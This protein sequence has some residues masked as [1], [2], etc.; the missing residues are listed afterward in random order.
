MTEHGVAATLTNPPREV[1]RNRRRRSRG[2][3]LAGAGVLVVVVAGVAAFGPL[4][5]GS[6]PPA[7]PDA[8]SLTSVPVTHGDLVQYQVFDG[9]VGFGSA[10][11][12]HSAAA[13]T[14]TWLA[15][16]GRTLK[17]GDT[18]LRVDEHPVV[19]LYGRLPMYRPLV[20]PLTGPDVRQF[21]RNL[22]QLGYTGFI[23]DDTYST[24]TAAAVKRWQ[25]DLGLAETGG[26][27]QDQVVYAKKA[28]R[29]AAHSVRVG[30]SSPADILTWT[31][32][33][34]VV[35]T[36]MEEADAL[37]AK[38]GAKVSVVL[39]DGRVLRGSVRSVGAG[40]GGGG[41]EDTDRPGGGAVAVTVSVAK[42]RA[43]RNAPAGAVEVRRVA[44]RQRDV[45]SVPVSALLALAE[46]GY[47]VEVVDGGTT[48]IVA[49][50]TGMFADGR[51]EVSGAGIQAG[52]AVMVPQ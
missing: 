21:E 33:T 25:A 46:G 48:R 22:R 50:Q 10:A 29:V 37:W 27:Q 31:G 11:L 20:A 19:L 28:V 17:R 23:V 30:A 18:I 24:S 3:L 51:V 5:G 13:G 36:S 52:Q 35:T 45:L 9:R 8:S 41:S 2:K 42:Q 43:L 39:P 15:P 16:V 40:A 1:L 47:G 49:V 38:P 6:P 4:T 26:V 44:Q 12:L 32:T 7:A 34:Q 14:V